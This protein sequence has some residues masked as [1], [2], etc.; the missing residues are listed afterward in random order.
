M[1]KHLTVVS[2]EDLIKV[3]ETLE[4]VE[5]DNPYLV[6]D[7]IAYIKEKILHQSPEQ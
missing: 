4:E 7:I 3:L 5:R 1:S 6:D 2:T